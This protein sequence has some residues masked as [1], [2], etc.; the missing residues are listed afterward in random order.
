MLKVHGTEYQFG[1]THEIGCREGIFTLKTFLHTRRNHGLPTYVAFIDLVKAYDTIDHELLIKV[2]E[3]YG[4]PAPLRRMIATLYENLII[5]FSL[6]KEK[7]EIH[8]SVGVRQGDNMAPVLFLFVMT[9]F[10][11]LLEQSYEKNNIEMIGFATESDDTYRTGQML[12]HKPNK[13]HRTTRIQIINGVMYVDD[14]A[15]IFA[16]RNEMIKALPLAQK[17]FSDLGMEMHVGQRLDSIDEKTGLQKIKESKT[18]CMFIPPSGYFKRYVRITNHPVN[19]DAVL[20]HDIESESDEQRRARYAREDELYDADPETANFDVT[21][22]FVSF[23][24]HFKYLGSMISYSLRD[25]IDVQRRID[26][27]GKPWAH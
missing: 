9:A 8:Q 27:A 25:D 16:P 24:K 21:G 2:L 18:E 22:G 5:S 11:T 20:D 14:T 19:D 3:K 6:G 1:G 7:I 10:H 23:T 13:L 4:V 26:A 12:R 17:L 15:L